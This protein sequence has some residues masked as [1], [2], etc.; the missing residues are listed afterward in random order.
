M[1]GRHFLQQAR[2]LV[3]CVLPLYLFTFLPLYLFTLLLSSCGPD[4]GTFRLE[5]RLRNM[6]Q[7]EFWVYSPDGSMAG[8]DTIKVRDGRF[9]YELDLEE[10]ATLVVVFPN[11]SEQP[12]FARPGKSV[13]IK[14]DATHLKEMIIQGTKD[15]EDMTSLRMEL[16][17]LAPLDIPAAISR[18]VEEH[19][20]S[21]A[22]VYAVQRYLLTSYEPSYKEAL[23]L[24]KLML[25]SQPDNKTLLMLSRQ[26]P[27]LQGAQP[28][29]KLPAFTAKDVKG[30]KVTEASLKA[31]VNVVSTWATWSY[32]ST[33]AQQQLRKLKKKYDDRLAIVSICLDAKVSDC[34]QRISR[35]SI[36]WPTVC[37]GR[38]WD[39]PLLT[40]F[41][42][43][44]VP[45][46]VLVDGKG[47]VIARGLNVQQL[48]ERIGA[49]LK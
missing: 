6:N 36:S 17:D 39:T 11:Y 5:G 10:D 1:A 43:A 2:K 49:L 24:T 46:I 41:G 37:D 42:M 28:G 23:R 34:R 15:N 45:D 16:N 48:E 8:I 9:A 3:K 47:S 30:S 33:A 27:R 12:V 7:G 32:Q 4:S 26:L 25:K 21:P 40:T 18:F 13:N 19:P 44:D 29:S 20:K 14:G 31:D 35:D 38:Q 22:S